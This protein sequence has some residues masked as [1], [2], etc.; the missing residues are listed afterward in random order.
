MADFYSKILDRD[1][2]GIEP[3]FTRRESLQVILYGIVGF[4]M[5]ISAILLIAI[6]VIIDYYFLF[7][8]VLEERFVKLNESDVLEVFGVILLNIMSFPVAF[9]TMMHGSYI[10]TYFKMGINALFKN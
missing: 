4:L 8:Y 6:I 5:V 3:D 2:R 10:S 1:L 9:L 7:K